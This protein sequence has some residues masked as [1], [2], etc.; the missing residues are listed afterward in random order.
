ME[1]ESATGKAST[2]AR[3]VTIVVLK[4]KVRIPKLGSSAVGLQF[5]EKR[6]WSNGTF[7]NVGS[8]WKRMNPPRSNTAIE[9]TKA[10]TVM[11]KVEAWSTVFLVS[12]A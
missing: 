8:P 5:V 6:N 9:Q 1:V 11:T 3:S 12:M 7:E 10:L 4:K 2:R